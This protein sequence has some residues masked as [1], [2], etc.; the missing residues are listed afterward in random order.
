MQMRG[1]SGLGEVF[2][3]RTVAIAGVGGMGIGQAFIACLVDSGYKGKIYP[4]SPKGG[5]VMGLEV[6]PNVV[7][8]PDAVDL[9]IACLPAPLAPQLVE[10]CVAKGVKAITFYTAGFGEKG[11]EQG[12]ALDEQILEQARAGGVRIL[13][14]NC[15]GIYNP[16]L[17]VSFSSDNPR[18]SGSTALIC[19][20]GG[21]AIYIVRAA[22]CRG[23]RFSKAVSYGNSLDIDAAELLEYFAEDDETRVIS[24]YIE[25]MKDGQR[26]YQALKK[27]C[28]AKPV[29]VVK[30]AQTEA[31]ARAASSHT[32]ALAGGD[33]V[34]RSLLRQA[35]AVVVDTLDEL[36]DMLVTF[37]FMKVPRGRRATVI[38][39]GG[40]FSV[41]TTDACVGHG[42]ELPPLPPHVRDTIQGH[43]DEYMKTDA[44]FILENPFDTTNL[45]DPEGHYKVLKALA[46]WEGVD[47]IFGQFSINNSAWPHADFGYS[48][49]P[50]MFSDAAIRIQNETDTPVA[51]AI[52][53][54]LSEWDM[55]RSLELQQKCY[56]GGLPV[57]RTLVSMARAVDRFVSYHER[58]RRR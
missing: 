41:M 40:G 21:N 22:G 56:E 16:K 57:F 43:V 7:D 50:G 23:V 45:F 13:G 28:S 6:Y 10:D 11:D 53:A 39:G 49:W 17:G 51:V 27:A 26:F 52:H 58:L 5:E 2:S 37:S 44:G 36:A 42:F 14:P 38:G 29:I 3:P 24:A 47:T 34:W 32:G 12:H 46:D 54:V 30:A 1:T 25:G 48:I 8:I 4:I 19:Q 33:I 35:G 55:R 31:G 9:V 15:V 18:E 20:S